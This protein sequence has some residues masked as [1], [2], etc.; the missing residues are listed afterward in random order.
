MMIAEQSGSTAYPSR[1]SNKIYVWSTA[2]GAW[3]GGE[4]ETAYV[5]TFNLTVS[6]IIEERA[7]GNNQSVWCSGIVTIVHPINIRPTD[8]NGVAFYHNSTPISSSH[9]GG[10]NV[11]MGDGS[12]RFLSD[13]VPLRQLQ[14]LG[15]GNDG[16]TS[17]L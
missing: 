3:Q 1:D 2:R 12:V 10:A 9:A 14:I 15:S 16:E 5:D 4:T 11:G 6:K 13:S 7:A 17:S 8:G